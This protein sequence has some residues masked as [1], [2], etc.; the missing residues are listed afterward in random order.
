M[1]A[2]IATASTSD[3]SHGTEQWFTVVA[4]VQG[5]LVPRPM[6]SRIRAGGGAFPR[7]M[8]EALRSPY[9]PDVWPLRTVPRGVA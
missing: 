5:V 1:T 2:C 6:H 9:D 3:L 7:S 8:V 4:P